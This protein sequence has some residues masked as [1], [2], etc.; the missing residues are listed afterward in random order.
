VVYGIHGFNSSLQVIINATNINV[1]DGFK[2]IGYHTS[3]Y[4]VVMLGDVNG[5]G[6]FDAAV[7]ASQANVVFYGKA[8]GNAGII[9]IVFGSKNNL[10][11]EFNFAD[12]NGKNGF[13]AYIMNQ[14]SNLVISFN[15]AGDFNGDGSN[16]LIACAPTMG[17]DLRGNCY[18]IL[19]HYGSWPSVIDLSK[20]DGVIGF[21]INGENPNDHLGMSVSSAGDINADGFSD[22][23]IGAPMASP[24]GKTNAGITYLVFGGMAP[25]L[26]NNNL[27]ISNDQTRVYLTTSNLYAKLDSG[28]E[29]LVNFIIY[30][31]QNG[32]LYL[33]GVLT[34][35]FSL[36]DIKNNR[37][38]IELEP[39]MAPSYTVATQK[40]NMGMSAKHNQ[41]T[42]TYTYPDYQMTL[43]KNELTIQEEGSVI[44][45]SDNLSAVAI[46][47]DLNKIVFI[48]VKVRNCRFELITQQGESISQ[49]SQ[50]QLSTHQVRLVA[51]G[52]V[53]YPSYEILLN[54]GSVTRGSP[55]AASIQFNRIQHEPVFVN[56]WLTI[57]C[58]QTVTLNPIMLK[59]TDLDTPDTQIIFTVVS[60]Q[61][62]LFT[63]GN[64]VVTQFT[65]NDINLGKIQFTHD[66]SSYEPSCDFKVIYGLFNI[67][68]ATSVK[69]TSEING[70]PVFSINPIPVIR[71]TPTILNAQMI[72]SPFNQTI[73]KVEEVSGGMFTPTNAGSLVPVTSFTQAEVNKGEVQFV[74]DSAVGRAPT[75]SLSVSNQYLQ[76]PVIKAQ[77]PYTNDGHDIEITQN[78]LDLMQGDRK[79]I[80]PNFLSAMYNGQPIDG[81][82]FV[83]SNVT[84]GRFEYNSSPGNPITSFQQ[85]HIAFGGVYFVHDGSEIAPRCKVFAIN[86]GYA[87][88][89][90][91][92][93][94]TFTKVVSINPT[95]APIA[96]DDILTQ[97]II[98]K[99]II[100]AVSGGVGLFFL[101]MQIVLK[102]YSKKY[103]NE[104]G[105][106]KDETDVRA[107]LRKKF[108][109]PIVNKLYSK[110][111]L[112][113]CMGYAD[114]DVMREYFVSAERVVVEFG[115]LMRDSGLPIDFIKMDPENQIRLECLIVEGIIK[116][117][118][119]EACCCVGGFRFFRSFCKADISPKE[120]EGVAV[121]I[122]EY[123][124]SKWIGDQQVQTTRQASVSVAMSDMRLEMAKM[125]EEME[126]CKKASAAVATVEAI[127][128][129]EED[130]SEEPTVLVRIP[131]SQLNQLSSPRHGGHVVAASMSL[132]QK[133]AG[134]EQHKRNVSV[135]A[136]LK[137]DHQGLAVSAAVKAL[138]QRKQAPALPPKPA[139]PAKPAVS[140]AMI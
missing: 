35:R 25:Y 120:I 106:C 84:N 131:A 88:Q 64:T 89:P 137:Q 92:T 76:T 31:L 50:Y 87:T 83:I 95:S 10:A 122:A 91:A 60:V 140:N 68:S 8:I 139:A 39:G 72:S 33:D 78:I 20:L 6:I 41:A 2:M 27:V 58:N 82:T 71:S 26:I 77:T 49:F 93:S 19:G 4:K 124:K 40:G 43:Q 46:G 103:L 118:M 67:T 44:L 127:E 101:I 3:G 5:D 51:T 102:Y 56:N 66:G 14:N 115:K 11:S 23:L 74:P 85:G 123:V 34:N 22:I 7:I 53:E 38:W 110:V 62:G 135:P 28:I 16:D 55:V 9:S 113:G 65:Q 12:L 117:L 125:R 108:I 54:D 57:G 80:L 96:E 17:F 111:T 128:V 59:V 24:Y 61:H 52:G 105:E 75:I 1:I 13:N 63:Y 36:L 86:N 109:K 100:G 98:N 30:D 48:P 119:P 73:F 136:E 15:D 134:I 138:S 104:A 32:R 69:F 107:E 79:L 21:K 42:I 97:E 45:S 81:L 47:L 94:V 132:Q 126:S 70:A 90:A 112:T 130:K 37:V 121:E 18:I 99:L 114:E 129:V 133:P 29:E 116:K